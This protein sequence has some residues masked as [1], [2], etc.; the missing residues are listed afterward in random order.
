M[1]P[2]KFRAWHKIQE[3]ELEMRK[4]IAIDWVNYKVDVESHG[5]FEYITYELE[6]TVLMQFTGLLDK[7]GKEIYEGD[8]MRYKARHYE[9]NGEV[10]FRDGGYA[11]KRNGQT[12][13]LCAG[14]IQSCDVMEVIG[15]IYENKELLNN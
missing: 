8:V 1:R 12:Y 7:N 2:I 14:A 10:V 3:E 4:V 6:D 5:D 11:L 9:F 15:N 13:E